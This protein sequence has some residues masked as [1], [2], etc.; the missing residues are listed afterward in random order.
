[1]TSINPALQAVFD[2]K[3]TAPTP[4]QAALFDPLT[5]GQSLLGLAPTGSGKTLAFALPALSRIEA[6]AGVQA[7]VIA[8]SQELA[9]QISTVFRQWGQTLDI[10]VATL[11]G[12]ANGRRQADKLKKD[13]PE[14]VVGTLG[15]VLT[16]ARGQALKLDHVEELIVDEADEV[17]VPERYDDLAWLAQHLPDDYQLALF[18]A[19][20]GV[21]LAQVQAKL[22]RQLAIVSEGHQQ[23]PA[24]ISHHYQYSDERS[25]IKILT[26]LA[27][28]GHQAL[29]FFN[30][31]GALVKAQ[32]ALQ[33]NHVPVMSLGANEKNQVNRAQALKQFRQGKLPLL[34]ATDVAARGLDIVDL[35]LV[36]NAQ[37][38][39]SK[40]TYIHRTGRTGRAGKDGE[41]LNLGNDHDIRNLRKLLGDT[42][43]LTAVKAAATQSAE[44]EPVTSTKGEPAQSVAQTD[45]PGQGTAV[46]PVAKSRP[47]TPTA[48]KPA[49]KKKNR[50]HKDKG[51]PKWAKTGHH[52]K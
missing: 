40:K 17:V 6:G 25:K 28:D 33:H 36:V 35:P 20:D 5:A 27:R 16:M 34:L 26:Q 52:P 2:Q 4:I 44:T 1:M 11:I 31:V 32:S 49:R 51:K 37:L 38:P 30:S 22:G 47:A 29:V 45:R 43:T 23:P 19:T 8:P 15:R 18:S 42:Y 9:V 41:I 12:G 48:A 46:K 13:R 50:H 21:D 3:F 39:R 7:I 14:V 24:V 10:R